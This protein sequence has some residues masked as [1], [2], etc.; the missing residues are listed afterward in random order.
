MTVA[1]VEGP[2]TH[3]GLEA[4]PRTCYR[5]ER[6]PCGWKSEE[7]ELLSVHNFMYLCL[8][9][10]H[11]I[12]WWQFIFYCVNEAAAHMK[13]ERKGG[14]VRYECRENQLN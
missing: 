4:F 14:N 8:F 10:F 7:R 12:F 13:W 9:I 5:S 11:L 6:G 1:T 3:S 2:A